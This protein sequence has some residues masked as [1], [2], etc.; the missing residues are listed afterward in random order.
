MASFQKYNTKDGPRWLYKYYGTINP[1]T[2]KRKQSTKRGFNTKKEAQLDAAQTEKEIADGTF[3]VQDKNMTFEQVYEQW[4]ATNSPSFKPSTRKA[5]RCKF[6]GQLLPHFGKL[7]MVDITKSYCQEVVNKMAKK[8][9]SVHDMKMY[10]NQI[11]EY[12]IEQDIIKTNPMKKAKIPKR[13]EEHF[14]SEGSDR[15]Y[16]EKHELKKFLAIAKAE[17]DFRDYAMFHT[18]I[19]TGARKGEVH[20]IGE[21]DINFRDKT[22]ALNKTLFFEDNVFHALTSKTAASRRVLKADNTTLRILRKLLTAKKERQLAEAQNEPIKF[23]FTREDGVTPIR[24]A[25]LNDLLKALIEKHKLHPIT[26]HGLRHTH[27]SMQFEAGATIK[28]VQEQLGHSDIKMTMDIYTHVTSTVK[29]KKANRF[30]KFME[31]DAPI[32]GS[33]VVTLDRSK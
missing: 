9:K 8:I 23:L 33:N 31:S 5:V 21:L 27:A 29:E 13:E 32:T 4:Y 7:K 1:E 19:Y 6:K 2:G 12:A 10:A 16:W 30:E 28:E 22:I 11:F 3:L 14:A 25:Y 24:L 18:L 20:A 26:V 17:C 15:N